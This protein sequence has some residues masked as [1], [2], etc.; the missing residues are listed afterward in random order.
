MVDQSARIFGIRPDSI[1]LGDSVLFATD[2]GRKP[3][4]ME[5]P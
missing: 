4:A 5:L 2:N 3:D 1:R